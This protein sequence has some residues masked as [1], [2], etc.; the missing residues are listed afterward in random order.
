MRWNTQKREKK[1]STFSIVTRRKVT[2]FHN[3]GLN[4]LDTTSY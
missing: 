1:C 4:I 3:F 2:D